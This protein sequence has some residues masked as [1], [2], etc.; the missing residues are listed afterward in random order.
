MQTSRRFTQRKD[1]GK[2]QREGSHLSASQGKGPERKPHHHLGPRQLDLDL[3]LNL[4]LPI[5][6]LWEINIYYLSHLIPGSGRSPG[7][8]NGNLLQ[9]PCLGNSTDRGAWQTIANSIAESTWLSNWTLTLMESVVL[10]YSSLSKV[11]KSFT[12]KITDGPSI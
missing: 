2:R 7:E 10:C 12:L 6:R 1:H 3:D 9:Y 8:G 11:I 4:G 5:S